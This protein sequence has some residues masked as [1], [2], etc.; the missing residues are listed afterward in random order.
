MITTNKH[1]NMLTFTIISLV[2]EAIQ[3]IHYISSYNTLAHPIHNI[4]IS[5]ILN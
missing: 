3:F 5:S 2:T 4:D 1:N